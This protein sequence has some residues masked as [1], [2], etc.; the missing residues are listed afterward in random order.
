MADSSR[1]QP[2]KIVDED[3]LGRASFARLLGQALTRFSTSES[4]VVALHGKFGSGKTSVINM[5]LNSVEEASQN[6]RGRSGPEQRA[7]IVFRF[8]PFMYSTTG[9]LYLRFFSQLGAKLEGEGGA[10]FK[11]VKQLLTAFGSLASPIGNI[12]DVFTASPG[13]FSAFGRAISAARDTSAAGRQ[14]RQ[15]DP[16][17][18]KSQI[19]EKLRES[20]Q[21][22]IIVVDDI[23]RL[24]SEE[25][26]DVFRLVKAVAD[27][28]NTIYLLAFDFDLAAEALK[29]VQDT[30]GVKYMEKIVQAPFT[31]PDI[32]TSQLLYLLR[33]GVKE[34]GENV[35]GVRAE[36]IERLDADFDY[37]SYLGF[38]E[39][40]VS[41]RQVNRL[42]DVLEFTLPAVAG[43]V[44]LKDYVVLEG[45]RV[46]Q[47]RVYNLLIAKRSFFLGVGG[48]LFPKMPGNFGNTEKMRELIQPE[49]ERVAHA[50]DSEEQRAV[51]LELL[52]FLFPL[53]DSV[54]RGTGFYGGDEFITQWQNERRV[55]APEVFYTA[56]GWALP[57]GAV[58]ADEVDD[59]LKIDDPQ[60]LQARLLAYRADDRFELN[61]MDAALRRVKSGYIARHDTEGKSL[62]TLIKALI[63]IEEPAEDYRTLHFHLKDLL[64]QYKLHSDFRASAALMNSLMDDYSLTPLLVMSLH[65]IHKRRQP[66]YQP[67]Q[68]EDLHILSEEDLMSV[69]DKA[70]A[71]LETQA[72][73]GFLL[74]NDI[75][76]AYFH[77]WRDGKGVEEPKGHLRKL[78]SSPRSLVSLLRAYSDHSTLTYNKGVVIGIGDREQTGLRLRLLEDFDLLDEATDV[79]NGLLAT[80]PPPVDQDDLTLVEALNR[81]LGYE[82]ERRATRETL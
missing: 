57:S 49:A 62:D 1:H 51:V 38:D 20:D 15:S 76:D 21:R 67:T 50:S 58:S 33:T 27:F 39:L 80:E 65:G 23:D 24:T 30:D 63:S 59:I 40:L 56:T 46:C 28:P 34:I 48:A 47:P 55:C 68:S 72:E 77:L 5:C 43:E 37:L 8:E 2:V 6:G 25:I 53:Y 66:D 31:L 35:E 61:M 74:E 52:R 78:L 16:E 70:V 82:Q 64:T 69:L 29:T 13:I 10:R 18:L 73:N 75:F 44:R 11:G 7:Q 9:Q 42:L 17:E 41:I 45:L 26:R 36:D 79:V 14:A 60:E 3:K 22:L 4:Y 12:L 81:Y 71:H 54:I 32:A 19:S